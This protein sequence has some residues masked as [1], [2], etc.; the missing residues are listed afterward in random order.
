MKLKVNFTNCQIHDLVRVVFIIILVKEL[1]DT[2]KRM[3]SCSKRQRDKDIPFLFKFQ[4]KIMI[5]LKGLD[6]FPHL[7]FWSVINTAFLFH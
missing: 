6:F 7:S 2:G 1:K 3:I 4:Y 5:E